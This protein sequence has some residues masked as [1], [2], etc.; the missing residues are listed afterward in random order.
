[1]PHI[2][3][4]LFLST[5]QC[6]TYGHLLYYQPTPQLSL[7]EKFRIEE[8]IEIHNRARQL[9]PNGILVKGNNPTASKTTQEFLKDLTVETIFE[10]TFL[11]TDYITKADILLRQ[12]TG[13]KIIEIK[14]A[15]NLDDKHIDDTG[16]PLFVVPVVMRVFH[17]H[18]P[19]LEEGGA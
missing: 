12:T 16:L 14:S 8:G 10:A 9:F 18:S 2:T 5:L 15:V 4:N 7:S 11:T 13:W 6:P 19:C 17:T 3:K 1:L